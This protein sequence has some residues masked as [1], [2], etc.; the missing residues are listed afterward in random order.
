MEEQREIEE[1]NQTQ[2]SLWLENNICYDG[3]KYTRNDSERKQHFL[4]H[5]ENHSNNNEAYTE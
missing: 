2:Q 5:K 4:K 3:E 1:M